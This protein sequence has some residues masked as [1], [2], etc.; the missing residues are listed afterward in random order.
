[1]AELRGIFQDFALLVENQAELLDQIQY[2]V[3][4]A[5]DHIDEGNKEMV[6]AIDH[7][8]DVRKWQFIICLII[9]VVIAAII[10][11]IYFTKGRK[12]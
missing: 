3:E 9:L 12:N 7:L 1:M 6:A 11:I 8:K 4:L 10:L 2:Q 5:S